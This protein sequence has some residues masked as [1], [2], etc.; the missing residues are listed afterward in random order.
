MQSYEYRHRVGLEDTNLVGNVY[1]VNHVRWQGRCREMFLYEHAPEVIEELGKGT[2]LVTTR[3]TCSYYEELAAFDE[4][5]IRM[6]AAAMTPS[7]LTMHFD[8]VRILPHGG[9]QLVARGE[10]E[11]ACVRREG[12]RQVATAL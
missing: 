9:E 12:S 8:Y 3:V 10:Q 2:S 5:L 4:V 1:Y 6:R 7:R 11:V